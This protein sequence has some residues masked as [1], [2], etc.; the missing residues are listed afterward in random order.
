MDDTGQVLE[1]KWKEWV[2]QESWLRIV[3]R[4]FECDCQSSLAL[5][6]PPLIS[7]AEM[8]LPLPY[9][10][11]LWH[12]P[13]ASAWKAAYLASS[14]TTTRRPT[15]YDCMEDL[16]HVSQYSIGGTAY[17]YMIW[18]MIWEYRQIT[19]LTAKTHF[20]ND[21][22]LA[23]RHQDLTKLCEDSRVSQVSSTVQVEI[24]L[25]A[26]LMHLNA[27]LDDVQTFA[28]IAGPDEAKYAYTTLRDW[29]ST[30]EA[31]QSLL[32]AS[33]ILQ[34]SESLPRNTLQNFYAMT[35]YHAGLVLWVYGL[36]KRTSGANTLDPDRQTVIL[37]GKDDRD[38]KKFIKVNRGEPAIRSEGLSVTV[39][40]RNASDIMGLVLQ[41][42]RRNHDYTNG[43]YP[44]LVDSLVQL[45]TSLQSASK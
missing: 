42:L 24:I 10:D 41:L 17:L 20:A 35:V 3:Y 26:L 22:L 4:F 45:M 19:A 1:T 43:G 9:S 6:K 14:I 18:G 36:L 33:R 11:F 38:V 23:S 34:L 32:H 37:G 44:R 25:E 39:L 27:P 30:G 31:R 15:L 13:S 29:A 2:L 28:G 8:K 12:A 7:Y 5:L 21:L 16:D 40:L